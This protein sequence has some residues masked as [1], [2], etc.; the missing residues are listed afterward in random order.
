MVLQSD[1]WRWTASPTHE[2]IHIADKKHLNWSREASHCQ[3]VHRLRPELEYKPGEIAY[4]GE[5]NETF[6]D[7]VIAWCTLTEAES[8]M[9]E[10]TSHKCIE[11]I[12]LHKDFAD[13]GHEMSQIE[14]AVVVQRPN[15]CGSNGDGVWPSKDLDFVKTLRSYFPL[16]KSTLFARDMV[17]PEARRLRSNINIARFLDAVEDGNDNAG[18]YLSSYHAP[19]D[20]VAMTRP[21]DCGY[22]MMPTV[23]AM[24]N[25]LISKMGHISNTKDYI[26]VKSCKTDT[27]NISHVP[28]TASPAIHRPRYAQVIVLTQFRG[29]SYFHFLVEC[30]PRIT[31]MLDVFLQ[32][33]DIK[34][35]IGPDN[36]K[37]SQVYR[38]QLIGLLGISPGRIIVDEK[39]HADV[40]FVP[41][42]TSCGVPN[43]VLV[44][45]LRFALLKG[46]YPETGGASPLAP[47]PIIVLIVRTKKRW[48]ANN[49]EVREALKNN[50][51][52]HDVM[53][54]FGDGPMRKQLELFAQASLIVGPHGAGLSNMI[55]APLHTMV[56]EIGPPSCPTCFLHLAVK[57]QHI[58][59]RH[60]GGVPLDQGC[61]SIY[62]PDVD[63]V[64]AI[65][66]S[67]LEAKMAADE[68]DPPIPLSPAQ[69]YSAKG[70]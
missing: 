45:R 52:T 16:F 53:E 69:N 60:Q 50:F 38:E 28:Q 23:V 30:L 59:A 40:A 57:L 14:G 4:F 49:D 11:G 68:A 65:I 62:T 18:L 47:R 27:V 66:R 36:N 56:L 42:S 22:E 3:E 35:V 32:Y 54:A 44:S 55:V 15:L 51:P 64:V 2:S 70:S 5:P 41:D 7:T 8:M 25:V 63:E 13:Y 19:P 61:Q 34:I 17:K 29:A 6:S 46:L 10:C 20:D 26:V 37:G 12:H 58:Y 21:V 9:G 67:L 33:H 24:A 31:V 1:E 43:T 39:I 48:L